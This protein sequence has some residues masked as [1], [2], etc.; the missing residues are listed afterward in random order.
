[1]KRLAISC[2]LLIGCGTLLG[3][4]R[5]Q[6]RVPPNEELP[7]LSVLPPPT[8]MPI[9]TPGVAGC[10]ADAP[11]PART[12]SVPRFTLMEE[13]KATTVPKLNVREVVVGHATGLDVMYQE[14]KQPITEW[15]LQPREVV[16]FVP[17]TTMMPVM[18]TDPC[19]GQCHTEYKECPTVREVR[20]TV[21]DPIPVPRLVSVG[22]PCVRPGQPL[23][24]SKLVVDKT[25]EPAICS[26]FQLLTQPNEVLVP[27]CP[28]GCAVPHP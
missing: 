7:P 17:C 13:Q 1:M 18:V 2:A 8:P 23:R 22:V 26:R 6:E 9:P 12:V 21:F 5:C 20:I 4:A 15:A 24:V 16:Q 28:P 27:A 3:D 19:T 25:I 14:M 10:P 11:C